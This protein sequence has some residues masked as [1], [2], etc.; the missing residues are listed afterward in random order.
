MTVIAIIIL[1]AWTIGI[2]ATAA[3]IAMLGREHPA[4][5][6]AMHINTVR[7]CLALA[8]VTVFWPATLIALGLQHLTGR[9]QR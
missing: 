7:V 4:L 3:G 1:T 2:I 8:L 5:D 9:G 6:A